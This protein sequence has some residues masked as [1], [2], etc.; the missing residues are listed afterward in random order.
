MVP[1]FVHGNPET[2]AVWRPLITM[3]GRSDVVTLSPPGFGASAP[4]DFGA[5]S[6]EYVDWLTTELEAIGEP[7]DLVGHDW[8]SNHVMRLACQRP[9]LLRS[10]CG[11]TAGAWAPDYVWPDVT[12]IWQK[13][14]AGE[15]AIA[16]QLAMGPDARA[17]LYVSIGMTPGPARELAEA[18]DETMG[19]CILGLYRSWDDAAQ[20]RYRD[21]L[22]AASARPGLFVVAIGDDY[23]GTE[24]QHRWTAAQAGA[25][26]AV[27]PGLGHWWMLHDPE[28][29]A[30]A[31]RRFWASV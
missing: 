1:V 8:G 28:A 18:F 10:W 16:A 12:H 2:S 21:R 7:V 17:E 5:T 15:N 29:G 31:L 22:P 3:L 30:D 24:T 9:D 27:L 19:R 11:D 14:G 23:T 6:D 20:A 13:P 4:D 26:V 25:E